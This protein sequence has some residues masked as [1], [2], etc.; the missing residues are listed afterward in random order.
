M[1]NFVSGKTDAW[2][3]LAQIVTR[4]ETEGLQALS[5]RELD[6]LGRLY[7]LASS[8][9]ARARALIEETGYHHKLSRKRLEVYGF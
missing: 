5:R 7:R 4:V 8:H 3:R 6:E 1:R 2:Q 9:L